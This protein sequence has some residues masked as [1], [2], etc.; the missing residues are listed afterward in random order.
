MRYFSKAIPSTSLQTPRGLPVTFDKVDDRQPG[1]IATEDGYI[2]AE[3]QNAIA[4]RR[5]G[6]S[7]VT[8]LEYNEFL[9]KKLAQQSSPQPTQRGL[10]GLLQTRPQRQ[11]QSVHPAAAAANPPAPN[12]EK[13]PRVEIKT[14]FP[15]LG[16]WRDP[17]TA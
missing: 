3:L 2:I 17:T 13:P 5:G 9:K 12:I 11:S 1:Y 8:E 10:H 15:K 4:N 7:E 16:R 14:E 6:I